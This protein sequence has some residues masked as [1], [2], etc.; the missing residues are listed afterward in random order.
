MIALILMFMTKI[1]LRS[2]FFQ[3]MTLAENG[4]AKDC[5]AST[6]AKRA[7]LRIEIP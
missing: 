3:V 6:D 5:W 7:N 4:L 2:N 1:V